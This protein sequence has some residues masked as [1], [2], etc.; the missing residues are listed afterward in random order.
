MDHNLDQSATF[1]RMNDRAQHSEVGFLVSLI[2]TTQGFLLLGSCIREF[3]RRKG[4]MLIRSSLGVAF[5]IVTVLQSGP[6]VV[7]RPNGKS[8]GRRIRP[9]RRIRLNYSM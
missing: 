8:W 4:A 2:Y 9:Q 1:D 5:R 6:E 7:A 3:L